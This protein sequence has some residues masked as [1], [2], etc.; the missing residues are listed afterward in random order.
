VSG[1]A[2]EDRVTVR[3]CMA[4]AAGFAAT[5]V[6]VLLILVWQGVPMQATFNALVLNQVRMNVSPGFWYGAVELRRIWIAWAMAGLGAAI[7]VARAMRRGDKNVDRL[8]GPFQVSF[9]AAGLLMAL[10]VPGLL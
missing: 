2:S 9:G 3:E 4:A 7:L 10:A 6:L 5:F 8:L 1:F